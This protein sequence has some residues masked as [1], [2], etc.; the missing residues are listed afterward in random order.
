MAIVDFLKTSRAKDDLVAALAVL[1]E[2]RACESQE[3]WAAIPFA[4]W[5]KLEQCE[6]FLAHLTEGAP[7]KDDTLAYIAHLA[8]KEGA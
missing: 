1:R 6:E 2:F 3:E 5:T 8:R 7:L 4:A